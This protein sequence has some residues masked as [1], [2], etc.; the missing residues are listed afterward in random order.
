MDRIWAPWRIDYIKGPKEEGCVFCNAAALGD[1]RAAL[2]LFRGRT[3][4]VIMNKYPY[5]NG[6]LMV[7]S[8]RHLADFGALT[9][10]ESLE[11]MRLLQ[12]CHRIMTEAFH[13]H[14]FNAGLNLGRCAGAGVEDHLHF[15][16]VPRWNGDTNFMPVLGE[17]RVISQHIE[18]TYDELRPFFAGLSR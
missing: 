18:E 5:N 12:E 15:H 3:A 2:I 11:A 6:H 9:P 13:P 14:G 16:I 4:F 7:A 8:F 10:D 1:D 17:T